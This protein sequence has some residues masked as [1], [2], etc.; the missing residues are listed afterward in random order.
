MRALALIVC[1]ACHHASAVGPSFG[2]ANADITL[3]R[4]LAVIRQK[5]TVR[6]PAT[7]TA[8]PVKLAAGAGR[9]D[10][11]ERDGV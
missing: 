2:E 5:V 11:L 3:Y 9:V 1:A 10:V 8:I 7:P 4:D 6:L